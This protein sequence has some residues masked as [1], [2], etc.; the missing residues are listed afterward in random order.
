MRN[1]PGSMFDIQQ[2]HDDWKD[3]VAR[4][5]EGW[6]DGQEVHQAY[7]DY[8]Y[9]AE[10]IRCELPFDTTVAAVDG[11]PFHIVVKESV[12]VGRLRRTLGDALCKR[13]DKFPY[14]LSEAPGE[15]PSCLKCALIAQGILEQEDEEE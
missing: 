13:A 10:Y 14:E 11:G 6:I 2:Y 8:V 1:K 9:E 15:Y 7:L 5:R 4:Y 3:A 12:T